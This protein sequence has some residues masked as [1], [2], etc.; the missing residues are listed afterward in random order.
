METIES[1]KQRK[2]IEGKWIELKG[3]MGHHQADQ[4]TVSGE[5]REKGIKGTFE[6]I[7][8]KTS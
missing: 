8:L 1:E 6:E 4:H 5:E 2:M 7:R 3:P